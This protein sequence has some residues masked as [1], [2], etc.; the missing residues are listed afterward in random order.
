MTAT[1]QSRSTVQPRHAAVS[2]GPA[3][4]VLDGREEVLLCASLFYFRIPR[5]QWASR[6]E[7]VRSSG[8]QAIDVYLPWNF[9]ELAPGEWDFT[10]RRD[11]GA[12]LDLAHEAGLV[13]VA[14]PG[15]YICSEWDGGALPAWLG[16]VDG[17]RIRQDEPRFLAAVAAWFDRALPILA[18]RQYGRG[19]SVV[20]VQLENE[21]DFFDTTDR[22]GYQSALRDLVRG[23][24]IELPLIACAGQG[25]LHGATGDAEGVVPACNFYPD[26]SSPH[27]EQEVRRYRALLAERDLPLLVT[28]TNRV[29]ATLR[30]LLAS[31]VGLIAPYLQASGYN[32]GFTPSVGNWGDPAGLMSHD[33][34]FAGFLSPVGEERPELHQARVLG[35]LVRTFGSELARALP[36]AADD[37]YVT[38]VATSASPSRLRL[39]DGGSL[40]AVP[41]LGDDDGEVRLVRDAGD[42][43]VPLPART[44]LLVAEDVPL[45]RWGVPGTLELA[46]AD[47]VGVAAGVLGDGAAGHAEDDA[48]AP[49]RLTLAAVDRSVVV[50]R[51]DRGERRVVEL[52]APVPG[53]AVEAS[54]SVG[55]TTWAIVVH[56]PA[57]VPGP[58]GSSTSA[59][60]GRTEPVAPAASI[61]AVR[62]CAPGPLPAER[63]H[64]G[65]PWSE[66]VG[67]WRGRTHYAADLRDVTQL[68]VEGAGD[69][70]DVAL[71]SAEAED[72]GSDGRHLTLTPYGASV[73]LDASGAD[74]VAITVE[75]WGHANFDDARLPNLALGSLR[76]LGAVWS[77]TRTTDVGAL[78]TVVGDQQWNGEPA[79]TRGLGGW[80]STR[81]GRLITYRRELPVD[82]EHHHALLLGGVPGSVEVTLDGE[83]HTVTA[84][85]PWLHLA[86][87]R[88]REVAITLPHQPGTALS[89]QLLRLDPVRGWDVRP[90][91]DVA[92]LARVADAVVERT[93]AAVT[94]PLVLAPGEELVV[95]LDVA[96]GGLS[97][98]FDGTQVRVAVVTESAG[99]ADPDGRPGRPELLGRVWLE[100][101]G[102]PVFTGGDPGRV[103]LP[104]AWNT[105]RV[106]LL[107]HG[108]PGPGTPMLAGVRVE[109]TPE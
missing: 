32:M 38:A 74:R 89:A 20:A 99:Q 9:H 22:R 104:G 95:E 26:D 97:L 54:V 85:N 70:V 10:G 39:P 75:T 69:I 96:A 108:T 88:G 66:E 60:T 56:H 107:L 30:R 12:F 61:D 35:A 52:D 44:C 8:Y 101:P 81:V 2:V 43:R 42:V 15:P 23:H 49:A 16:T 7:Q 14:R 51:D 46:T 40:L 76:G 57:D 64:E 27:V 21:L 33:Y 63:R 78:W 77:V 106:R 1:T 79:P 71:T 59:A 100:D 25:D 41:N 68:L 105:G 90:E 91:P 53:R 37:A 13:V 73:L 19:G 103:W 29:H 98:R 50:L 31:G 36:E 47:L 87:G 94:L 65:T 80:S 83:S 24:G 67:V 82:G 102:R 18:A 109:S 6:L 62:V 45:A 4:I 92:Y 5:E 55:T 93:L 17:L 28:E 11:V 3:G 72:E 48:A 86:P 58:G 34:D 84:Q